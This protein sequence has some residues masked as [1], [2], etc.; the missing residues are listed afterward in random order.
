MVQ[1]TRG[2][3]KIVL[4]VVIWHRI[5]I[6]KKEVLMEMTDVRSERALIMSLEMYFKGHTKFRRANHLTFYLQNDTFSTDFDMETTIF[7]FSLIQTT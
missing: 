7:G 6:N 2:I 1:S 4:I 5:F 3:N